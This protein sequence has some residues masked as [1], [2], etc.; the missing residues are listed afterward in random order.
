MIFGSNKKQEHFTEMTDKEAVSLILSGDK[1]IYRIL[2]EKYQTMVFRICMGFLH[3]KDD[4]DDLTQDI[5][6]RAYSFLGSFKGESGFSTWLYRI[7]INACL[8]RTRKG[9]FNYFSIVSGSDNN[10]GEV[11]VPVPEQELPDNVLIKKEQKEIF[12][13][14]LGELSENLRTAIVL[15]KYD[16]LSQKEIA[17]IMNIS[18]SAVEAL[19]HRAKLKLREKLLYFYKKHFMV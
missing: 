3:N 16:D 13:K 4:A 11:Q 17:A 2:V 19:L 10:S 9:R 18:E 14:A 12:Q 5:F 6:I 15:S 7:S 1:D 8:N